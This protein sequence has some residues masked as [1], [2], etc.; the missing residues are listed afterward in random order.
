MKH[1]IEEPHIVLC[2]NRSTSDVTYTGPYPGRAEAVAAVQT[3]RA[4]LGKAVDQV[5]TFA[6][7]PLR[8]PYEL[9]APSTESGTSAATPWSGE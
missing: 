1:P 4:L 9:T 6:T 5:F 3:E 7:A 8:P 2:I